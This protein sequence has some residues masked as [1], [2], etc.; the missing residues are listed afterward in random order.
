[1]DETISAVGTM[2]EGLTNQ[3]ISE[4]DFKRLR[5]QVQKDP[6]TQSAVKAVNS[7][8]NIQ[9]TCV[10]YCPVDGKRYSCRLETCADHNVK[11]M[12]VE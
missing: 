9:D 8:F 2:T 6:E 11:L 3:D 5:V 10:K 12:L 1:M 4:E 7:A